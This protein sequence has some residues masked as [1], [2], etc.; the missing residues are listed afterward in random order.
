MVA[1]GT[2]ETTQDKRTE[3]INLKNPDDDTCQVSSEISPRSYSV[4]GLVRDLPIICG[5]NDVSKRLDYLKKC[6]VHKGI[7]YFKNGQ[8]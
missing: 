1:T 8:Y 5:G 4:G 2:C 7:K 3:I 6:A